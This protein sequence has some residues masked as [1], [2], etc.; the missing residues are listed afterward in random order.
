MWTS[1]QHLLPNQR[2]ALN[3]INAFNEDGT[4]RIFSIP[5]TRAK[6]WEA[7]FPQQLRLCPCPASAGMRFCAC[8][9]AQLRGAGGRTSIFLREGCWATRKLSAGADVRTH[10]HLLHL[11]QLT[12]FWWI[13]IRWKS[14]E[15]LSLSSP[16][17]QGSLRY[18]GK[19]NKASTY[20]ACRR[21][22]KGQ[23][24]H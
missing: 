22:C 23:H 24:R 18:K 13:N 9:A 20:N 10:T 16:D 1:S 6:R 21:P 8:T 11:L 5:G 14:T 7:T 12:W 19:Y 4:K 3:R 15:L 2:D 17:T